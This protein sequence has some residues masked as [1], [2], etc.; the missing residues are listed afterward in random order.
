MPEED[1]SVFPNI[2]PSSA[3][4]MRSRTYER[5]QISTEEDLK[6]II[7]L[8]FSEPEVDF[9]YFVEHGTAAD[10]LL[11]LAR[12]QQFPEATARM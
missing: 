6:S 9:Y 8:L 2:I 5:G 12:E 10:P 1:L 11:T 3:K 4:E 7:F